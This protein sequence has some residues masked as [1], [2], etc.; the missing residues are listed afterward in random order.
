[1]D[2][3]SEMFCPFVPH[4]KFCPVHWKVEGVNWPVFMESWQLLHVLFVPGQKQ[5]DSKELKWRRWY[6]KQ[7]PRLLFNDILALWATFWHPHLVLLMTSF[8]PHRRL[9]VVIEKISNTTPAPL[10]A[11]FFALSGC[12]AVSGT[13]TMGTAWHS[14]S[15]RPCEPLW[16]MKARAPGCAKTQHTRR[17]QML[18]CVTRH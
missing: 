6:E 8:S 15:K 12:S 17:C 18:W 10:L 5:I 14:P 1:M 3:R 7:I 9:S 16:V 11:N 13:I 2:S 4:H